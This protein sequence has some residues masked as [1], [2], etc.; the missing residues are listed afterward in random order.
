MARCPECGGVHGYDPV[1]PCPDYE[2][3]EE[4]Y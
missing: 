4:D 2:D 3:E 1:D